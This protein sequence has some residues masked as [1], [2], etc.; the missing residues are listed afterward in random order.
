MLDSAD[1]SECI[2][3]VDMSSW[4]RE[5]TLLICWLPKDLANRICFSADMRKLFEL[6][7]PI[8]LFCF[9][10]AGYGFSAIVW[11]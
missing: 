1:E 6:F 5:L 2:Q 7:S 8:H 10:E 3:N 11:M 9:V 4:M